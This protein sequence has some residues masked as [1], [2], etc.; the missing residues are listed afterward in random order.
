MNPA[1][2]RPLHEGEIPALVALH[3]ASFAALATAAYPPSVVPAY[4]AMLEAPDYAPEVLASDMWVA[5]REGILLG[6]AG[7]L[8]QADGAARIRKVFV[9]PDAARQGLA[10]RL[11]QAAEE[12]A[13]AAGHARFVLRAYLGAV[14]FYESL[15]YVAERPGE[16]PV[17][18]GVI[19]PVLFMRKD[20]AGPPGNR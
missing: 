12:R 8:P 2:L 19:L 6:S 5:E 15:G 9:H 17:G 10:T 3:G 14:P 4:R 18:D 11:V 16:R 7:W 1:R 13:R 20:Q